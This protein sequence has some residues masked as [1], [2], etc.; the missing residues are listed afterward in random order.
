[1]HLAWKTECVTPIPKT[2][3]PTSAEDLRNISCTQLLSKVYG[4]FVLEWLGT[5]ISLRTNQY[6]GTKGCGP[7][8]SYLVELWQK[9]LEDIEDPW[10]ASSAMS[11]DYSKAFNRLDF[12]H[13]LKALEAKKASH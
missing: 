11:I 2:D 12:V 6:G 9:I 1:M 8:P 3:V 13:C 10:G 4:S 5:Q 7:E